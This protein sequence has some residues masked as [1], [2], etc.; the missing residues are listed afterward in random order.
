MLAFSGTLPATRLA[1][2]WFSPSVLTCGRIIIAAALSAFALFIMRDRRMP[3]RRHVMGIAWTGIGLAIGYPLFVALAV[4]DVPASHGAVVIGLAPAATAILSVV[5]AGERPPL[6]FWLA[7][8]I[9]VVA[10]ALFAIWQGG[11]RLALA[12][13]WLVAAILSVGIGY[14]EGGRV[15]RELGGTVTLCWAMILLVPIASVI[16]IMAI[17]NRNWSAVPWEAWAGFW[18]AGAISMFLGSIAWYEGLAAGGIARIGQLN[19]L[20]PILALGWSALLLEEHVPLPF[21]VT[22]IVVL[23][24]MTVCIRS[25]IR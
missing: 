16:L 4:Q 18:Y 14:V 7:C 21:F 17:V 6:R 25:R 1:V 3:D 19:L 12:D 13:G 8:G 10:V 20:Q 5:R 22:A 11:G 15:S 24:A 23:V 9:G 2:P